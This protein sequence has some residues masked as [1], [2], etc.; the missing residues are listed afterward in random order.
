MEL[1]KKNSL[2]EKSKA[3]KQK[4]STEQKL[5]LLQLVLIDYN[6]KKKYEDLKSNV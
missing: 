2:K 3:E 5:K 1:E 4:E 6:S